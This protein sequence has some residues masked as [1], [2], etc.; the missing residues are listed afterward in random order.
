[1]LLVD[2]A[3]KAASHSRDKATVLA[4]L[5][6]S[7]N[8]SNG[9]IVKSFVVLMPNFVLHLNHNRST[10]NRKFFGGKTLRRLSFRLVLLLSL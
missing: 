4:D 8:V 10:V 6:T 7:S 3:K 5:Q 2:N 1:M 9:N